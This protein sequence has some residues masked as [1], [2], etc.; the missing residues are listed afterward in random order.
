MAPATPE[1]IMILPI[2]EQLCSNNYS[3]PRSLAIS[4]PWYSLVDFSMPTYS[5]P[6]LPV[7]NLLTA[8]PIRMDPFDWNISLPR[9][10]DVGFFHG[11]SPMAQWRGIEPP[12]PPHIDVHAV[13]S[14]NNKTLGLTLSQNEVMKCFGFEKAGADSKA[15][16]EK[17]FRPFMIERQ[18]G[19]TKRAVQDLMDPRSAVSMQILMSY[20]ALFASNDLIEDKAIQAFL[21]RAEEI[22]LLGI[23]KSLL[24]QR[25]PSARA[26]TTQFFMLLSP[27]TL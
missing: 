6:M 15:T 2:F 20:M 13:G 26:I 22:P 3:I 4:L 21:A 11:L 18:L 23:V 27:S 9:Q 10:D 14:E 24:A 12:L 7:A 8:S 19:E 17:Y 25:S 5:S 1:G 16:M